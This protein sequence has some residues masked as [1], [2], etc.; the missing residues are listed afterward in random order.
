MRNWDAVDGAGMRTNDGTSIAPTGTFTTS[1]RTHRGACITAAL[2]L[3]FVAGALQHLLWPVIRP[4]AWILFYPA[5]FLS[6]WIGG[7]AG[8][9]MATLVSVVLVWWSF[10][11]PEHTF[12]KDEPRFVLAAA[13]FAFIGILFSVLGCWIGRSFGGV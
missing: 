8:G 4:F 12:A 3:P 2:L 6:S 9:V 7:T 1:G 11:P 13:M 5:V 10:V